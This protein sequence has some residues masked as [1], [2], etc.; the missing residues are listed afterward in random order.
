M[1]QINVTEIDGRLTM[2]TEQRNSALNHAV[3]LAGQVATLQAEIAA[4]KAPRPPAP[5]EGN[6][7]LPV[8]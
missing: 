4:L 7:S 6:D 3:L 8:A 5:I 2:L 1:Q